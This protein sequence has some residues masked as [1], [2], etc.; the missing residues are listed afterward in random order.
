MITVIPSNRGQEYKRSSRG[1]LSCTSSGQGGG[2]DVT[3]SYYNLSRSPLSP[4]S[5][6]R[7]SPGFL[8]PN[9]SEPPF[10][11]ATTTCS[12]TGLTTILQQKKSNDNN[13]QTD[14][15]RSGK[16]V[17][18]SSLSNDRSSC[19]NL[20]LPSSDLYDSK[21]VS[22]SIL[23]GEDDNCSLAVENGTSCG[24]S[25][26]ELGDDA[27]QDVDQ[28]T[29]PDVDQEDGLRGFELFEED[30]YILKQEVLVDNDLILNSPAIC[31]SINELCAEHSQEELRFLV[32]QIDCLKIRDCHFSERSSMISMIIDVEKVQTVGE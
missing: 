19:L 5:P 6:S 3:G 27:G 26:N 29:E 31:E 17:V 32:G 10:S 22:L 13:T 28:L 14:H 18:Q 16:L 12:S 1:S 7:C 20:T 8:T 23:S 11:P 21:T 30:D 9:T 2:T 4:R 24:S 15:E 25:R